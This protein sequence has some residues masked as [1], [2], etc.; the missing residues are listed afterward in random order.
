M[1]YFFSYGDDKYKNSKLRIEQEAK[2][3]G[4]FGDIKIYGPENIDNNFIDKTKPWINI[5][6]GGG[7]WLWK[8]FFLK[9]TFDKMV[10]GDYV[11]YMDAG[12]MVNPNGNQRFIEYLKMLNDESGILSFRMDGLDEEQYTTEEIFKQFNIEED[13]NI[14]KSGQIMATILVMRKCE[15]S[16][17]LVNE[18]YDLAINN[19]HLFSDIN[20]NSGNCSRFIDNRHDQSILSVL[21]KKYGTVEI[22]DETWAGDMDAWNKLIYDKKIPFL[23]TRIR[24]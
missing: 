7:L 11:V 16:I 13:S 6:R 17:N 14:R 9:Q 15:K 12:C 10:D 1:V 24:N 8:S 4:I 2:N 5:P 19:T 21:R 20:N 23:A 22:I 18:Y 3:L